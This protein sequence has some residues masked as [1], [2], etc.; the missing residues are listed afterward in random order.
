MTGDVL[1]GAVH[2]L[3]SLLQL[4]HGCGEQNMIRFAPNVYV[5]NYLAST[6]QLTRDVEE[7]ALNLL[8]TGQYLR[9]DLF[10]GDNCLNEIC[11]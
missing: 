9:T 4:P 6:G 3:D 10:H 5:L 1:G 2:H 8:L 7:K 11:I